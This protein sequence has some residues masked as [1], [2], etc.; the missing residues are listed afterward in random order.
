MSDRRRDIE[1]PP[2]GE[3]DVSATISIFAKQLGQR[4]IPTLRT[5]LAR[6]SQGYPWLLKKLCIHVRDLIDSG[7][8]QTDVFQQGLRISELFEGDL[9]GLQPDEVSCLKDVAERSPAS[10]VDIAGEHGRETVNSLVNRRLIVRSADRL[11]PY[12]DLFGEFLRTG[13]APALSFS[14]LPGVEFSTFFRVAYAIQEVPGVSV[15]QIGEVFGLNVKSA[16]NVVRDLENF[17]IAERRSGIV[18]V[19]GDGSGIESLVLTLSQA[20]DSHS[21]TRSLRREFDV[22]TTI[23]DDELERVLQRSLPSVTFRTKTWHTYAL[24]LA[25][26]LAGVGSLKTVEGGWQLTGSAVPVF[27]PTAVKRRSGEFF[28]DA[29]PERVVKAAE[30]LSIG[31][32]SMTEIKQLGLRNAV[33]VL[34]TLKLVHRV[35]E[36]ILLND[37]SM[38]DANKVIVDAV[39]GAK[40]FQSAES[41]IIRNPNIQG[42]ALGEELAVSLGLSWSKGSCIRHGNAFKRWVKWCEEYAE[43]TSELP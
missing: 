33:K 3:Q 41:I 28:A 23:P 4:L 40:A 15:D 5:Q 20:L 6:N 13:Q 18:G 26:Y 37:R 12:W 27:N 25:K 38:D 21:F 24:R 9:A 10:F 1:L 34:F 42:Q 43:R 7:M 35:G 39:G 22:Q 8:S 32:M 31:G 16:N 2:F 11:A 29:P 17:G 36:Q 19:T 14:Y 30:Q